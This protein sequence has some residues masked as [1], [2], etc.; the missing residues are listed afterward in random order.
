MLNI[1]MNNPVYMLVRF[2]RQ[3]PDSKIQAREVRASECWQTTVA[4]CCRRRSR[5]ARQQGRIAAQAV[6]TAR[7]EQPQDKIQHKFP[8]TR[9]SLIRG[10]AS[11]HLP[12]CN[13]GS[14][15]HST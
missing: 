4:W 8:E 2:S 7:T 1:F 9:R 15:F 12:S 14:A 5:L 10:C 3:S 13:P 6:R 11:T